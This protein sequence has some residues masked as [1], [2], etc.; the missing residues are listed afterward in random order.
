LQAVWDPTL[1]LPAPHTVNDTPVPPP[2]AA[3]GRPRAP[4][5]LAAPPTS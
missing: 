2:E 1:Q 3:Q 4:F 5:I